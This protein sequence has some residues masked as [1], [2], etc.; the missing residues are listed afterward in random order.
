MTETAIDAL[1]A[2][3]LASN[4]IAGV[5]A[6]ASTEEGTPV[7]LEG[8]AVA[9]DRAPANPELLRAAATTAV[10]AGDHAR[11][12][13]FLN[14][15]GRAEPR[16]ATLQFVAA[17][18]G[19]LPTLGHPAIR[20]SL[21]SS[22]TI[23]PLVPFV[24]LECRLLRLEPTIAVAP[25]NTWE[26]EMLGQGS[27]LERFGPQIVFLSVAVEDLLPDLAG[28]ASAAELRDSGLAAVDRL[29][30]AA[31]RF[32]S[33][34]PAILVVHGLHSVYRDPL[35]PAAARRGPSR[36][37][38]LSE[39][40][41]RLAE[42]LR[43]LPR[44]YVLD[45]QE[46]LTRRRGGHVDNPKLRHLA[47]MRLSEG[48]LDELARAYAQFVAPVAGRIRKCV[49]VDLDNTLWGGIVG[50]DGP[51][52]IRLGDTAPG[53]EYRD[54]QKYL[55]GL[56]RRGI[57]LAINSKNNPADALEVIRSHEAMILREDSFSAVRINWENKPSNMRAIA[58]ELSLGLDAMVFVD[59]SE[60]ER[61]VMRQALP[62]V[63]TV[64]LPRDPALY[65]ETL[66]RIPELQTLIVTDEDR[67]RTR[68]YVERREREQLRVSAQSVA[69]YLDSLGIV[70]DTTHVSEKT[71]PRVHQLFQRTNQFNLTGRRYELGALTSWAE[72]A[73]WRIYTTQVSDR[74]GDHGLVATALVKVSADAW[75]I[76]NLVMSCRVIGYGVEDALLAR[77][78]ADARRASAT[79]LVGEFVPSPKNEPARGFYA[80]HDFERDAPEGQP[81]RWRRNVAERAVQVPSWVTLRSA[82]GA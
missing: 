40:N 46:V 60:N 21:L 28:P 76:D 31:T 19:S 65:R 77:L 73:A 71:L 7:L 61:A 69:E 56:T 22:F 10:R 37:E 13:E 5:I 44:A 62:E 6:A 79:W 30:V 16:L 41:A 24:D 51:N 63:L 15:L 1:A 81:E 78:S 59:D 34:S 43:A 42:G 68:Q 49:V 36:A 45:L 70:I 54:F 8:L 23:E 29:L 33:W 58:E 14:R 11:A 32:T 75:V 20:I 53:V 57:L 72:D 12:H 66:E 39:L 67:S 38:L 2:R 26:R 3:L 48:V 74:F 64:E 80:R 47:K 17:T 25:F 4:D 35:G 18:R 27:A 52:G 82:N 50:E 55:L 9:A